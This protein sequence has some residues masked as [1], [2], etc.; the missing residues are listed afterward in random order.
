MV[1]IETIQYGSRHQ[2]GSEFKFSLRHPGAS[3]NDNF[4]QEIV[5]NVGNS[6]PVGAGFKGNSDCIQ[7]CL[8]GEICTVSN[9]EV[10]IE[11][12]AE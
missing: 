10:E 5:C 7:N 3:F 6:H 8:I 12:S 1:E 9:V 4:K 11:S 2:E